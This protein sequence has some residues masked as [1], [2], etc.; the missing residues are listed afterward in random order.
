ML[1]DFN[2]KVIIIAMV[3]LIIVL[4]IYGIL[5]Y[6]S[7]QNSIYPT[8]INQCPDYWDV[9]Y[10]NNK[11]LC[12]SQRDINTQNIY[13]SYETIDNL[14]SAVP[15]NIYKIRSSSYYYL[16]PC[17]NEDPD[18]PHDIS[19]CNNYNII[20]DTD[21]KWDGITNNSRLYDECLKEKYV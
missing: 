20:K 5:I 3:I 6:S 17:N 21:I 4:T 11:E 12:K 9:S 13:N 18:C 2:K 10:N 19:L 8:T 7:M 16:Y 15:G 14:T 1:S